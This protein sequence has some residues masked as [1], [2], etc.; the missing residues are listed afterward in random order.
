M[1]SVF[2]IVMLLVFPFIFSQTYSEGK[3]TKIGNYNYEIY[4]K[5]GYNYEVDEYGI[6]YCIRLNDKESFIGPFL[7]YRTFL[8][9]RDTPR[10][11]NEIPPNPLL[12]FKDREVT[13]EGKIEVK[14]DKKEI[15]N[16]FIKYT[17]A[18]EGEADSSKTTYKQGKNGL[19]HTINIVEYRDGKEKIVFKK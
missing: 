8:R 9:S 6:S 13:G 15:I 2:S 1:K 18:N 5:G 4:L 19:F 17:K 16:T 3:K 10:I 12:K 11:N 7:T 14:K